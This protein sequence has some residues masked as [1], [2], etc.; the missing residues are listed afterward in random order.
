MAENP[1]KWYQSGDQAYIIV[2]SAMVLVMIPALGFLYSGLAR[3]TSALSLM[4]ACMGAGSVLT[5]QWYLWGSSLAFSSH[6]T[7]GYIDDLYHFGLMHTLG[8][9]SPGSPLI[10]ELLFAFHQVRSSSTDWLFRSADFPDA[11]RPS[12]SSNHRRCC[13]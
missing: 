13:R 2:A 4:W 3:R 7:N 1:N 9:L 5:F 12:D 11:I 10:P 8:N 6:S